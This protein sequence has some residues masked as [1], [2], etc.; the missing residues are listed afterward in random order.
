MVKPV[1][2]PYGTLVEQV[3]CGDIV[4]TFTLCLG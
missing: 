3:D 4:L 2:D 1:R